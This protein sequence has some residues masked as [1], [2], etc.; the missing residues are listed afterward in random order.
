VTILIHRQSGAAVIDTMS[1]THTYTH[2]YTHT[3]T[4]THIHTHTY[5]HTHTHTNF[6]LVM[7]NLW[8]YNDYELHYYLAHNKM[9]ITL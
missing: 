8:S 7:D 3:H 4:H 2:T 9:T 6:N 1:H 5:T